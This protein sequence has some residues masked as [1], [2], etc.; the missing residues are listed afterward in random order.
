M[1]ENTQP[2]ACARLAVLSQAP[3]AWA[4]CAPNAAML[5]ATISPVADVPTAAHLTPSTYRLAIARCVVPMA[6]GTRRSERE[7][8]R[9]LAISLRLAIGTLETNIRKLE[10]TG[11]SP[12]LVA[13]RRKRLARMQEELAKMRLT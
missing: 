3:I 6:R 10:R 11:A 2:N 8:N 9:R 12:L 1:V 5:A 7:T 13:T 4:E